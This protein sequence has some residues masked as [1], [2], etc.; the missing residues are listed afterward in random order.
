MLIFSQLSTN[1]SKNGTHG[2]GA[3]HESMAK[4]LDRR[5]PTRRAQIRERKVEKKTNINTLGIPYAR[6]SVLVLDLGWTPPAFLDSTQL[7]REESQGGDSCYTNPNP[8]LL[9]NYLSSQDI[10]LT[11]EDGLVT[12]R[13]IY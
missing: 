4:N 9:F 3:V 1:H 8:I 7:K 12:V 11:Q 6:S 5:G 10:A 13:T 2:V